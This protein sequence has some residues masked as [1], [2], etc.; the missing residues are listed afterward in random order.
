MPEFIAHAQATY[1][2]VHYQVGSAEALGVEAETLGGILAW[3]SLIHIQPAQLGTVLEEFRRC[4]RP[5]GGLAL[6]FFTGSAL[7]PFEHAITT[8]YY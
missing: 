6:G 8:A 7:A 1:P 5:G 2:G 3:Y 4:L